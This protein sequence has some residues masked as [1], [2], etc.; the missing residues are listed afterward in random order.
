MVT[1][2]IGVAPT[3]EGVSTGASYASI[4]EN[5]KKCPDNAD[6][7][8]IQ[9]S[10]RAYLWYIISRI[11]FSVG[12]SSNA[13][14]MWLKLFAGWELNLSWGTGA[15]TYLYH[16][17]KNCLNVLVVPI[18]CFSLVDIFPLIV[19]YVQLDE[20]CCGVGKAASIGGCMVL[21]SI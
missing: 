12:T 4:V 7:E 14:Y 21:L 20:G 11:L 2:M 15:L 17:V 19:V 9:K 18:S 3:K 13:T 10:A 16:Q 6:D 5:S 8:V 1:D